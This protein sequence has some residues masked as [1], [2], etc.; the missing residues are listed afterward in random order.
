MRRVWLI[1]AVM[2][3]GGC[4]E[5][6]DAA[7]DSA[8]S[9][10]VATLPESGDSSPTTVSAASSLPPSTSSATPPAMER[11]TGC[12][13]A[14]WRAIEVFGVPVEG[15]VVVG[16]TEDR[17]R[18]CDAS[19][20]AVVD[21]GL[22]PHGQV[23]LAPVGSGSVVAVDFS[24]PA[25]TW[26]A[27]WF[28]LVGDRWSEVASIRPDVGDDR[29]VAG[30]RCREDQLV[31]SV[32]DPFASGGSMTIS[33]E[34]VGDGADGSVAVPVDDAWVDA[35]E[36]VQLECAGALLAPPRRLSLQIGTMLVEAAGGVVVP[37]DHVV[38][39]VAVVLFER[40]G[41]GF[42]VGV[43]LSGEWPASVPESA[44]VG[45]CPFG[46]AVLVGEQPEAVVPESLIDD[47]AAAGRCIAARQ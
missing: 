39:P 33:E 19:T 3:L 41:R 20:G 31:R 1:A 29:L 14:G 10:V 38:D 13:A 40:D 26:S 6:G 8:L 17:T 43:D 42:S 15:V 5:S 23:G 22:I 21:L 34:V 47:V 24:G 11:L 30:L 35:V 16:D 18:L 2:C 46:L 4:V 32:V 28:Q 12:A 27:W 37:G 44:W 45:R 25:G 9:S 36:S 7:S